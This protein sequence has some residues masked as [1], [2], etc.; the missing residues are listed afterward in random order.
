MTIHLLRMAVRIDSIEHLKDRQFERMANR[1]SG[2]LNGELYTFTRNMPRRATEILDG[3]SIYWVIKRFVRVRQRIL[4]FEEYVGVRGRRRCGIQLEPK[5][6]KTDPQPHKAFRG[7]RYL[8]ASDA[9]PDLDLTGTADV[10]EEFPAEMAD[11]LRELG[12]L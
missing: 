3:G 2:E 9:P 1:P 4:G 6:I 12:L 11:E 10:A 7:W 8:P 5:W